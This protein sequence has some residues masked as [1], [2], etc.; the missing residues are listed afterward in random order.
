MI[1]IPNLVVVLFLV[2]VAIWLVRRG[3]PGDR[4]LLAV[5]SLIYVAV[6][7]GTLRK[8]GFGNENKAMVYFLL[9]STAYLLVLLFR[10]GNAE[11]G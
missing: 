8:F 6:M 9:E 1:S 10:L 5:A 2:A 11:K 4:A 7:F 3:T